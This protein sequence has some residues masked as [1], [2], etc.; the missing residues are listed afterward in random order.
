MNSD[1]FMYH[2]YYYITLSVSL[3]HSFG[4]GQEN[5]NIIC[6]LFA[7]QAHTVHSWQINPGRHLVSLLSR[8]LECSSDLRMIPQSF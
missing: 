1:D 8:N 3:S 7:V 5:G 4:V 2:Y 6:I